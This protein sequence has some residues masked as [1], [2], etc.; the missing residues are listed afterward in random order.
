MSKFT[1]KRLQSIQQGFTIVELMIATLVF[2][3]ILIVITVGVLHFTNAYYKGI[4]SSTTQNT[5]R[6]II[7]TVSQAIEFGSAD[8][9][10][11]PAV[12]PIT[13][14]CVGGQQFD[15]VLGA[16]IALS[17]SATQT[18]DALYQRPHSG[19]GCVNIPTPTLRAG[20]ATGGKELLGQNMRLSKFSVTQLPSGLYTITVRVVYGDDALLISPSGTI[21]AYSAPDATCKS[22]TGSQF[23]A[24][25]ELSTTVQSRIGG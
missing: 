12:G 3:V 17:P 1:Y 14:Y 10:H 16:E 6:N 18:K 11:A 13:A 23:C 8:L 19:S 20:S 22:Q 9:G 4:N 25:S 21:P 5:A 15:F 24:A 7:D 2:S